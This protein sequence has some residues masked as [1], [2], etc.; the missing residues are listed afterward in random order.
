MLDLPK[1]NGLFANLKKCQ[2]H[3]D[4]VRFLGYIVSSQ[5][6]RMEDERIKVIR[7]WP[8]LKSLQDIQVFI[9]FP[10]F[11]RQFIR[12][13]SRI[14]VPLISI[15]ETTGSSDL[16][17]KDNDNEV[18]GGGGN[19][20]NLSKSKK[21]K[22]AKSRIQTRIG[23]TGE[24]TFLNTGAKEIFNQLKQAFTKVPIL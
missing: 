13:F 2:F 4:K 6:I 14:A 9:A 18:V 15:L 12:S 24:P 1:K 10:N 3:K 19:D 21:S 23:A 16:A 7:N 11:Y 5:D 8:E 22:N 20:R 17:Q